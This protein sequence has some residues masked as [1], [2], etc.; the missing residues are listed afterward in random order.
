MKRVLSILIVFQFSVCSAFATQPTGEGDPC[1]KDQIPTYTPPSQVPAN[2]A[3]KAMS[4]KVPA[5][6]N[7]HLVF[8][9]QIQRGADGVGVPGFSVSQAQVPGRGLVYKID[10]ANKNPPIAVKLAVDVFEM[11][12]KA[13]SAVLEVE[14]TRTMDIDG[15]PT[16]VLGSGS[17]FLIGS[18]LVLTNRHVLRVVDDNV[19]PTDCPEVSTFASNADPALKV[20]CQKIIQCGITDLEDSKG[21]R[22]DAFGDWCVVEIAPLKDGSQMGDHVQ[23][24][25]IAKSS[26]L[27]KGDAVGVIGNGGGQGI[28]VSWGQSFGDS[29]AEKKVGK[30][31]I[32]EIIKNKLD[33]RAVLISA[34]AMA[35]PGNSG[36]AAVTADGKVIGLVFAATEGTIY[37]TRALRTDV[38]MQQL[39][40]KQSKDFMKR[41][42]QVDR[43]GF[44]P[45]PGSDK[46]NVAECKKLDDAQ[47]KYLKTLQVDK[48]G[49]YIFPKGAPHS[50]PPSAAESG[51]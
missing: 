29:Q 22:T 47:E 4:Q 15:K 35:S 21:S 33:R 46:V 16:K 40:A 37:G 48:N 18:N 31:E 41:I 43:A 39:R 32:E 13:A 10:F 1:N 28:Q 19:A 6:A 42:N 50:A 34:D 24:L 7:T 26:D 23:P 12:R 20:T 27:Q 17:S 9:P 51:Q 8:S 3:E 45:V 14:G 11:E 36:G 30:R 44:T 5:R 25:A 38:I 2:A 49:F